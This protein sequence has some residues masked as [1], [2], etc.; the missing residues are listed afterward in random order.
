MREL[1]D[2]VIAKK[3]ALQPDDIGCYGYDSGPKKMPF[4]FQGE[5]VVCEF[6]RGI[7]VKK[8]LCETLAE[9]QSL[10]CNY[11]NGMAVDL[12]WCAVKLNVDVVQVGPDDQVAAGIVDRM[13][14]DAPIEV[15]KAILDYAMGNPGTAT[16]LSQQAK[17]FTSYQEVE[18]LVGWP[19]SEHSFD[20]ACEIYVRLKS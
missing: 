20:L 5:F 12:K 19:I 1:E 9:M 18:V 14:P 7:G 8:L 15:K 10:Y 6:D 4:L 3:R 17:N 13:L 11:M 2:W 16:V